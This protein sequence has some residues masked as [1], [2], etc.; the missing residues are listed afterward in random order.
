MVG[1]AVVTTRPTQTDADRLDLVTD[2]HLADR[3]RLGDGVAFDDLLRQLRPRSGTV[4]PRRGHPRHR[5]GGLTDLL[6]GRR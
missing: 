5:R 2:T 3:A 4:E 6:G 1:T